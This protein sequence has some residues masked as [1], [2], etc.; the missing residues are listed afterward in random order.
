GPE[1]NPHSYGH[2]NFDKGG[3]TIQLKKDSIFNKWS[4]FNW[5]STKNANGSI[6]IS[7]YKAQVQVFQR[8]PNKTRYN[9]TNR[10]DLFFSKT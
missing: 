10:I 7:L 5:S 1:M 8:P 6:L 9:E 4:W 3:K 2:L